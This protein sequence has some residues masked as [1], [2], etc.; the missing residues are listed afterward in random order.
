[1][2]SC[3]GVMLTT[4]PSKRATCLT[5]EHSLRKTHIESLFDLEQATGSMVIRTIAA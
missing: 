4:P 1:M 5:Q 3:V 2:E